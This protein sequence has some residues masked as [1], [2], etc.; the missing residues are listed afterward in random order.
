MA[1]GNPEDFANWPH[2]VTNLAK[3]NLT[4]FETYKQVMSQMPK[5]EEHVIVNDER[6]S[7]FMTM[8]DFE[9]KWNLN[10]EQSNESLKKDI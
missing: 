2:K 8:E 9:R 10:K 7:A 3:A 5:Q 4:T 6:L 1:S